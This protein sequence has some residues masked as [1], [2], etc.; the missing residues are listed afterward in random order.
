MPRTMARGARAAFPSS[1]WASTSAPS[2][3]PLLC[4]LL[5]QL[6]GWHAGFGLA[7]L[8]M[9]I[10]LATYLIGYKYLPG[11]KARTSEAVQHAPLTG[12]EWRTIAA[13]GVVTL[14]TIFQSIAYYQNTNVGLVWADKFVDLNFIGFHMPTAWFSSIDPF[15]SVVCVP[16]LFAL[17]RWQAS[18]GQ[19]PGDIG[20]IAWGAWIAAIAN[21]LSW[22]W[23][24]C[25]AVGFR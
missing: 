22:F 24:A 23:S 9:L 15:A 10:G 17:W 12:A 7:G 8:L 5:A 3:G 21:L 18:R 2:S 11:D 19:E 6:Y 13:L 20:K 4:G 16:P 1:P 25:R 14:I